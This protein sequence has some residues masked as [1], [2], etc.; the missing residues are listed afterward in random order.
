MTLTIDTIKVNKTTA[1]VLEN[2]YQNHGYEAYKHALKLRHEPTKIYVS[3]KGETIW[4]NLE[5]RRQRP[6]TI[7]KKEI[8]PAVLAKMGLPATTKVRWS[9]YAGCSCPCSPGFIVDNDY[10]SIV[11]ATVIESADSSISL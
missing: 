9:Q 10:G 6:Y 3:L 5:K 4:E 2:V 8:I 1:E 7:F 11:W